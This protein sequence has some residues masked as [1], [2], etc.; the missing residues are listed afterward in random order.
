MNLLIVNFHYFSNKT[1][2]SGIYPISPINFANQI[3]ILSKTYNFVSQKDISGWV[4]T[5]ETPDGN[6]CLITFDDGLKQQMNAFKWLLENKI[7]AVFYVPAKP[8]LKK[9]ILDVHKLHLIRTK[10]NDADLF[11]FI[12]ESFDIKF[13][14]SNTIQ[15]KNQYK[16]DNI[17]SQKLKYILN[18]IISEKEK[19]VIIDNYFV[20]IFG[21]EEAYC[22]EFYMDES[23]VKLLSNK[24][25]LGNH[26]YAH[27]PLATLSINDAKNDVLKSTNFFEKLTQNKLLSFSYPY[28]GKSAVND[29][30]ANIVKMNNYD[31]GLTMNRGFNDTLK[32]PFLL[33]RI[34]TNDA[35]GGKNNSILYLPNQS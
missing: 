13:T 23:D 28:G 22:N 4:K 30:I 18:F 7:P 33:N 19:K 24:G 5:G 8:L 15:A 32:Q 26:G 3:K 20:K 34:D 16:Y 2:P 29:S 21:N 14:K 6:F 27:L 12:N 31:F 25:M 35:P 10:T 11:K 1:Y 9:T 17:D